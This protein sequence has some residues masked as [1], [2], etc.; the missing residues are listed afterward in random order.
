MKYRKEIDGLRALAVV[1][2]ILFHAGFESFHGGFVGVDIFFVISGYLITSI[3]IDEKQRGLFSLLN[4]YE[5]RARRILPT[6]FF[7]LLICSLFAWLW[8][9]PA[10]M[11][12]FSQSLIAVSLFSSNILFSF[13]SNYFEIDTELKPLLHT[14]SLAVEEQY[15]VIFPLFIM[16]CWRFGKRWTVSILAIIT[17]I[18]LLVAQWSSHTYPIY[19][20]YLL[21]TRGW[22]ILV[23]A[24]IAFYFDHN[25]STYT[26]TNQVNLIMQLMSIIGLSLIIYSIFTFDKNLPFPSIYTLI[27]TLGAALIILYAR[28]K[29]IVGKLLGN[30]F[31]VGIG[32][33]SI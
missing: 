1:P 29:T 30:Q 20:F 9:L 10:E 31:F 21:P 16:S 6:L 18:S 27:P 5:R 24:F 33:I 25:K 13:T 3:I 22:E 17:I 19:A 26:K 28:E 14:W 32:L 4:F 15:Y 12:D 2:V 8:L 7:I 23:G 11:K